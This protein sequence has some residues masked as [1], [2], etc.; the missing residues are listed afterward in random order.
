MATSS[1]A[2]ASAA[3]P[4]APKTVAPK[5]ASAPA[6]TKAVTKPAPPKKAAAPASTKKPA[7]PKASAAKAPK[8]AASHAQRNNYI[9]V[10]AYYIAERRGFAPGDPLADWAEAEAE[11]DRLLAEGK[12]NA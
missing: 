6:V 11:I 9:E 10:A 8:K 1:K 4:K 7:A 2:T 5:K 3:K 12:L